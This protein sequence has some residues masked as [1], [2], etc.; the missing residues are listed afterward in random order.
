MCASPVWSRTIVV[1]IWRK[2]R[3]LNPQLVICDGDIEVKIRSAGQCI[4]EGF[5]VV[6]RID[7]THLVNLR[8]VAKDMI[9]EQ[10]E[11]LDIFE[12]ASDG[13]APVGRVRNLESVWLPRVAEVF[14]WQLEEAEIHREHIVRIADSRWRFS[15]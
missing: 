5:G 11:T 3:E 15:A 7:P 4:V 8:D 14:G 10:A 6:F 13:G 9:R 1:L 12:N 2:L